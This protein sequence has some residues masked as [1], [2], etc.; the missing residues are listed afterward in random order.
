MKKFYLSIVASFIFTVTLASA[1]IQWYG[2]YRTFKGASTT[3][4]KYQLT[5]GFEESVFLAPKGEGKLNKLYVYLVRT[6]EVKVTDT[7]WVC[8]DP[9]EGAVPPMLYCDYINDCLGYIINFDKNGWYTIDLSAANIKVGGIDRRV[10]KHLTE[11]PGPY[12]IF[13]T[14]A[15]DPNVPS[16]FFCDVFKPNPDLGNLPGI[17]SL[18]KGDFAICADIA[19]DYP[20]GDSSAPPPSPVLVDVT[21]SANLLAGANVIKSPMASV[22]DYDNDGWD[23]VS[24]GNQVFHNEGNGKFKNVS[25]QF[26]ISAS[27]IVWADIDNDGNVDAFAVNGWKNDRI[28]WNSGNGTFTESTDD[29]IKQDAP[30]VTPLLFDYNGDGLLDIYM[31]YGR[32]EENGNE[33]YYQDKLFLN[34]GN[35]HFSDVTVSTGIAAGESVPLDSWGAS[36]TDYNNDNKP[37]IFV[38][39]YRL[40]PDLLYRNN[41]NN[42]FTEVGKST[43]VLGV[44]TYVNGSYGH[45]MGSDWGDYNNDGF[46]DLAVGNLGHPDYRALGS[47][48]SEIFKNKGLPN[49]TF[50]SVTKSMGLKFFE[51]NAGIC[52]ADLN[53]D[54]WLDLVHAQYSYDNKGAGATRYSRFYINQGPSKNYRLDDKTWEY[55][56]LIH[57]AWSPIRL[58]Y[59]NDGDVDIIMASDKENVKL[60]RNDIPHQGNWINLILDATLGGAVNSQAYGSSVKITCGTNTYFRA[61]PGVVMNA[62]A[63]QSTNRL[64]FG[65]GLNNSITKIEVKYEDGTSKTIQNAELNTT[66]KVHYDGT[67]TPLGIATP[68]L[69]APA[70]GTKI[71]GISDS[72]TVFHS[73]NADKLI[74]QVSDAQD[75]NGTFYKEFTADNL[76]GGLRKVFVKNLPKN[77]TL[78]WRARSANSQSGATSQFSQVWSF[79]TSD[80]NIPAAPVLIAPEFAAKNV[81][82]N[83]EFQWKT[84][85]GIKYGQIKITNTS[86]S[87]DQKVIIF[88]VQGIT[89]KYTLPNDVYTLAKNTEYEWGMRFSSTTADPESIEWSN[90]SE[91]WTFTTGNGTDVKEVKTSTNSD[92]LEEAVPNP[93]N[94]ITKFR[95]TVNKPGNVIFTIINDR[96]E[97]IDVPLRQYLEPGAYEIEWD[98][99]RYPAGAYFYQLQIGNEVYGKKL[100]IVK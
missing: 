25:S 4:F 99:S 87:D 3:T 2:N 66:Y 83:P 67:I 54:G 90:W 47:N 27:N 50:D 1:Q 32:K 94:G 53:L 49:F 8:G 44:P 58:D 22:V 76:T 9:S 24:I 56:A 78:Y 68:Q 33:T 21:S 18:V 15:V 65:V 60:F 10:V 31:D 5:N 95:F 70:S 43:G 39:T 84:V 35:R 63:S 73:G 38:A 61:L 92:I 72:M 6:P 11:Q 28:Y 41:G 30:S 37:D 19:Y 51:M 89:S 93:A 64:T 100:M 16:S 82:I 75:F 81:A 85:S 45:G 74:I 71:T 36:V 91:I 62:Q 57:G 12:F 26:N 77:S 14:V 79:S 97:T 23:D 52:W 96:P 20:K 80:V 13:D 98:A 88:P 7:I 59:D 86:N 29:I 34:T 69:Y 17:Y 42:T 40:A 46:L 55:G 48:P